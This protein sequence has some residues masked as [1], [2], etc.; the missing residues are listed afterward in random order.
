[1]RENLICV[2]RSGWKDKTNLINVG[3]NFV[4]IQEKYTMNGENPTTSRD[5]DENAPMIEV[6]GAENMNEEHERG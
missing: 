2:K 3:F 4:M 1:M 6:S 5:S